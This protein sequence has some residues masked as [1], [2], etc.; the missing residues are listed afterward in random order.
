MLV[1]FSQVYFIS[2]FYSFSFPIAVP[3]DTNE[4]SELLQF[5]IRML[6]NVRTI[7]FSKEASWLSLVTL[8]I[9]AFAHIR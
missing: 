7:R 3:S 5:S 4:N 6:E 1:T 8:S 2:G 9:V